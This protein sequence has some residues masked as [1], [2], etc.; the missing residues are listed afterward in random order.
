[1]YI[2]NFIHALRNAVNTV[3]LPS[4][5]KLEEMKHAE[6]GDEKPENEKFQLVMC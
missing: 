5:I 1:M 6:D 4:I 3:K 2:H